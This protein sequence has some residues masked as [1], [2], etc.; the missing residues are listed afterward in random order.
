[1]SVLAALTRAYGRMEERGLVPPFG[2]SIEN[3]SHAVILGSDGMPVGTP[4]DLRDFQGKK[5]KPRRLAVP[6]GETRA[7]GIVSN[8]LWD[9]TA[10]AL[11]VSAGPGKRLAREHEAFK[12][13]H[14]EALAGTEDEGLRALSRFLDLWTPDCFARWSWPEEMLD[15]N[16][17]FALESE[18]LD[19]FLHDRPAAHRLW[20]SRI[21]DAD[22]PNTEA[23]GA[24]CLVTGEKGPAARLHRKIKGVWGAQ[25]AGA[26][27]VSFN[28]DAFTSYGHEQGGNAPVGARAAFAYATVLNKFLETGSRHRLQV[29]DASTVFWADGSDAEAA[30]LAEAAFGVMVAGV[31][32]AT[33][34]ERVAPILERLRAGRPIADFAPGLDAGV[35]FHVLGLAPN[36]GRISVRFW[37]E[38]DFGAI[39]ANYGRFL[40]DIAVEPGPRNPNTGLFGYLIQTAVQRKSENIPPNLA[41]A[42]MRAILTGARYPL[43][44]MT[45]VLMRIRADG[46]VNAE[47]AGMV[48]SVLIGTLGKEDVPVALDP[49]NASIG[50][51]LGRL[52]AV[53]ERA[54]TDA[55]GKLNATIKDRYYGA[56]SAQPGKVFPLLNKGVQPHLS[57]LGKERAGWRNRLER[58]IGEIM[59]KIDPGPDAFPRTL[60]LADQGLFALGYYHQRQAFF[61]KSPGSDETPEVTLETEAPQ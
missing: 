19:R 56:A 21:A 41:G 31:D 25:G 35:R 47:R 13:L 4:R 8:F 12:T 48:K 60:T 34:A 23:S 6:A 55:L 39:A 50:Y 1:M 57:K 59:E 51:L 18:W 37:V 27:L 40:R 43:P 44:L 28:L 26:S 22:A 33:Q 52:F 49:D 15:Q 10:Y 16:I 20:A 53:Y 14:R 30:D 5:P 3:I 58:M 24:V 61:N 54:Q 7:S 9:K 45:A 42:W 32:D 38:D 11:G 46:V 2:Y 17:V 29:G 36:A